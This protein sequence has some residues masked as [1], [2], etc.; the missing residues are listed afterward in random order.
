MKHQKWKK[1]NADAR[2][3]RDLVAEN[4]AMKLK[5]CRFAKGY[6]RVVKK[7]FNLE[8]KYKDVVD[9][10][11]FMEANLKESHKSYVAVYNANI[12][13]GR[14]T[15]CLRK[16]LTKFHHKYMT[17]NHEFNKLCD[18]LEEKGFTLDKNTECPHDMVE[19]REPFC[20]ESPE[21]VKVDSCE[22]WCC[23]NFCIRLK[24]RGKIVCKE[25]QKIKPIEHTEEKENPLNPRKSDDK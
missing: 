14:E 20:R 17:I 2:R 22:C 3:Y 23:E 19:F 11:D 13:Q 9:E 4:E 18:L 5:A 12:A 8:N 7:L 16:E 24:D 15:D 25:G 21:P 6:K 10:L 1:R